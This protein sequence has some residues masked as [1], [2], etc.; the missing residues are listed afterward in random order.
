MPHKSRQ[1]LGGLLVWMKCRYY[2][3]GWLY[4]GIGCGVLD[5]VLWIAWGLA[6][7]IDL[8]LAPNAMQ[9]NTG[10]A[11]GTVL[12]LLAPG[13]PYWVPSDATTHP[14]AS[15][16]H[17]LE[18]GHSLGPR[19]APYQTI[20][21]VGRGAFLHWYG[22]LYFSSSDGTDP[23]TNGR[24]YTIRVRAAI[25]PGVLWGLLVSHGIALG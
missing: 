20:R 6:P 16:L 3:R 17:L 18:D 1:C 7:T 9:L 5:V 2:R 13:F 8:A 25:V 4:L 24:R 22:S 10:K 21:E 15:R 11:Y 12:G 19:H 14:R 23:R